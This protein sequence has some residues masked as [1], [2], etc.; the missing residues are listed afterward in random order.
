MKKLTIIPAIPRVLGLP[1]P[2]LGWRPQ[3]WWHPA[4][5]IFLSCDWPESLHGFSCFSQGLP[6]RTLHHSSS[7]H[8]WPRLLQN[9]PRSMRIKSTR[10]VPPMPLFLN[11]V[12]KE[13]KFCYFPFPFSLSSIG[14]WFYCPTRTVSLNSRNL[15]L[16]GLITQIKVVAS[17]A[18]KVSYL[19]G[20]S[21]NLLYFVH[22]LYT[23]WL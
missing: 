18:K 2:D 14:T 17:L 12:F 22:Y 20:Y 8:N 23:N 13:I 1:I 3:F 10:H 6:Y 16:S 9:C 7:R 15:S 19:E 21:R 4:A 11:T 5:S